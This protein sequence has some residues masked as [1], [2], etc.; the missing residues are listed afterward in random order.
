MKIDTCYIK[1]FRSIQDLAVDFDARCIIIE[2]GNGSGKT[3]LLEALYCSC[4]QKSFRTSD[5]KECIRFAQEHYAIKI[6]GVNNAAEEWSLYTARSAE[7]RVIKLNE[8]SVLTQKSIFEIYKCVFLSA[9]DSAIIAG[10]P[11]ARRSFFD[12]AMVLY[13]PQLI[14]LFKSYRQVLKQRNACLENAFTGRSTA[15][16]DKNVH[17]RT[18]YDASAANKELHVWTEKLV[19]LSYQLTIERKAFLHVMQTICDDIFSTIFA[20]SSTIRISLESKIVFEN[21]VCESTSS[22]SIEDFYKQNSALLLRE[23]YFKKTLFGAHLDDFKILFNNTP[24]KEFASRGQQKLLIFVLKCAL[25]KTMDNDAIFLVDDFLTDFD[26]ENF[27]KALYYI[28]SLPTQVFITTPHSI[29]HVIAKNTQVTVQ[30]IFL[31]MQPLIA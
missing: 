3:S 9:Q 11:E 16:Y 8:K 18:S 26:Q 24:A 2:G 5:T 22:I 25:L 7:R 17:D 1:N 12:N 13:K 14:E 4:F 31:S 27:E 29:D 28:L 23:K 15:L 6:S 19:T 10:Y 20:Q 21:S 30:K